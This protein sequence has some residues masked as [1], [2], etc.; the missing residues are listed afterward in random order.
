MN[1]R[2]VALSTAGM[3]LGIVSAVFVVI[4]GFVM[5][6]WICVPLS[7]VGL[8]L[9]IVGLGSCPAGADGHGQAIT[10]IVLNAI[11]L[12]IALLGLASCGALFGMACWI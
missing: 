3:V 11:V 4:G 5:T 7:I 9:A 6:S 8:A 1:S 12:G 10:G 2:G